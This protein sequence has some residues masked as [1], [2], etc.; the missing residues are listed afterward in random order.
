[1]SE[2]APDFEKLFSVLTQ[3]GIEFVVIGGLAGI[4]HGHSR[5]TYDID[6]CYARTPENLEALSRVLKSIGT[7][8]RVAG[9]N[10]DVV[11]PFKPD[12]PNIK[13]L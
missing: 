9:K 6:V 12:V 7:K 1:M 8:L 10:Q 4:F 5:V 2:P 3:N 13:L 11:L